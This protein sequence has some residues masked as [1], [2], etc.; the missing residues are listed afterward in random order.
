MPLGS[1]G[2][3]QGNNNKVATGGMSW[4]KIL[5]DQVKRLREYAIENSE[6]GKRDIVFAKKIC[7]FP[8]S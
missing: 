4:N 6:M 7:S 3:L 2:S 8:Y 1:L 5:T